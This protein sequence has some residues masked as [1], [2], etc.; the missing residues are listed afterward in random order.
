MASRSESG[1]KSLRWTILTILGG[2][3][4]VA[5]LLVVTTAPADRLMGESPYA[6]RGALH[7]LF[8]GL[9]MITATIGLFQ[10]W[11]LWGGLPVGLHELQIGSLLNAAACGWTVL[12]GNW[13]YIPYRAPGGPRSYFLE[14]SPAVHQIFF[15]FKEF[16]ALFTVPLTV[17]AAYLTCWYGE[18]LLAS[19]RLRAVTAMVL[20]LGFFYFAVAFGLGA[21][22]TK[23][24]AV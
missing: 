14:V 15:E 10:A 16:M 7:G 11:R 6:I 12:L 2:M 20:I 18:Q 23:L 8:A 17:V 9:F 19:R 21:A 3:A 22:V 24:R 4:A 5:G 1:V 13:I